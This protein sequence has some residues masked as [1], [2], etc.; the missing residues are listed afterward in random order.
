MCVCVGVLTHVGA[1]A[2]EVQPQLQP[3]P[4]VALIVSKLHVGHHLL[5]GGKGLQSV[6][7]AR[8]LHNCPAYSPEAG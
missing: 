3:H 5:D 2:E 1:M 8:G 7:V 6:G 4:I